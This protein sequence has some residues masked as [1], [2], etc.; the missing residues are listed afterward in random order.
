[1]FDLNLIYD[2]FVASIKSK[3]KDEFLQE[4]AIARAM[5]EKQPLNDNYVNYQP[6][7]DTILPHIKDNDDN[8]EGVLAA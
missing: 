7:Y 2:D 1:M 5:C 3:T 4:L 8:A 6:W